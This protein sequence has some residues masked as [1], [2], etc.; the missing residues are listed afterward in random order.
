M[1]DDPF[2][3]RFLAL[4]DDEQQA[5]I[6]AFGSIR[7]CAHDTALIHLATGL[8]LPIQGRTSLVAVLF[9]RDWMQHEA[10][11]AVARAGGA[12]AFTVQDHIDCTATLTITETP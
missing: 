1:K 5:V 3:A 9:L 8:R 11:E 6:D 4:P 2:R 12:I 7:R 10:P